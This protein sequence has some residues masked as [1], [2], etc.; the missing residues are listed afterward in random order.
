MEPND[1]SS[2]SASRP[3]KKKR[4]ETSEL[5][6]LRRLYFDVIPNNTM[7]NTVIYVSDDPN[8]KKWA[9]SIDYEDLMPLYKAK[10][11]LGK[12]IAQRFNA[13]GVSKHVFGETIRII[14]YL[15]MDSFKHLKY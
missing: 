14:G 6:A 5:A 10:G 9:E 12:F 4:N 3:L 8:E 2:D 1:S 13:I 7:E 15:Y 11:D